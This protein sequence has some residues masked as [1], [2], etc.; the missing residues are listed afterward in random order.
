MSVWLICLY[1][2]LLE[3][4]KIVFFFS[5]H[6]LL[7]DQWACYRFDSSRELEYRIDRQKKR[8]QILFSFIRVFPI[9][10]IVIWISR[11]MRFPIKQFHPFRK[12]KNVNF[13][14]AND[15]HHYHFFFISHISLL[16]H[17]CY[18]D[19][20]F[21]FFDEFSSIIDLIDIRI[22]SNVQIFNVTIKYLGI[23]LTVLMHFLHKWTTWK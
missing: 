6:S 18:N 15:Q 2:K 23:T 10:V 12:K 1:A 4:D 19:V 5:S 21:F 8:E 17:L 9:S 13:F 16:W 7:L 14:V 11:P 20:I 22:Q 3:W